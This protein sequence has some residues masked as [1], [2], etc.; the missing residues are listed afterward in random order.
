MMQY[1]LALIN[2]GVQITIFMY[3]EIEYYSYYTPERVGY[4]GFMLVGAVYFVFMYVFASL[5]GTV[6]I[7]Y[8]RNVELVLSQIMA[9][10]MVD[11]IT[12]FQLC[13][14]I[15]DMMSLEYYWSMLLI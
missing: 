3:Y 4:K 14:M 13:L 2:L 6:R 15:S 9:T 8:Q 11:I 12:Y 10:L 1:I 7:G 5:Y